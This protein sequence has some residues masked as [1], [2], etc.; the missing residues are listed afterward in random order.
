MQIIIDV[1]FSIDIQ[2]HPHKK[3]NKPKR[4]KKWRSTNKTES[5]EKKKI[6]IIHVCIYRFI[7]ITRFGSKITYQGLHALVAIT[8][9]FSKCEY[10]LNH[11][12]NNS[13]L[14]KKRSNSFMNMHFKKVYQSYHMAKFSNTNNNLQLKIISF[15]LCGT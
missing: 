9:S 12:R 7:H 11:N 2:V 8:L 10:T 5:V 6:Q 3:T 13:Y 1:V 15:W 4:C 14:K